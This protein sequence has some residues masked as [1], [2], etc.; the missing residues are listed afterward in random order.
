MKERVRRLEALEMEMF[1]GSASTSRTRTRTSRGA[2]GL[3][4]APQGSF[5][6]PPRG[7]GKSP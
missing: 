3:G 1:G 2:P 7:P 5:V 6:T 4:S